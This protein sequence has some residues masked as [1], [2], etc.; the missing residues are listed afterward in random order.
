[1]AARCAG[2]VDAEARRFARQRRAHRPQDSRLSGRAGVNVLNV[3]YLVRRE[4]EEDVRQVA[5]AAA[6][7]FPGA[8]V[9]VTGPWA[10]YSFIDA[11]VGRADHANAESADDS[12]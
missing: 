1:M 2:R 3:A 6:A 9:E 5:R 4:H 7:D 8:R 10:P 11:P 12:A